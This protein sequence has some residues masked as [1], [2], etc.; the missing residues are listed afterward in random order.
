MPLWFH[1]NATITLPVRGL[2]GGFFSDN[3]V[4]V[5]WKD[6]APPSN[7][8]FVLEW[9]PVTPATQTV[10]FHVDSLQ[11]YWKQVE[12]TTPIVFSFPDPMP[13]PKPNTDL[14]RI[15]RYAEPLETGAAVA[16]EALVR[17][18]MEYQAIPPEISAGACG[19]GNL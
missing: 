6:A 1:H 13:E 8:T 19:S 11:A 16:Q 15:F 14:D 2:Q 9:T 5:E 12:G 4:V 10:R 17:I 3:C 18:N 7:G